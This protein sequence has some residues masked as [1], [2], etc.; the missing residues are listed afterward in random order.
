M[1]H[2]F[3]R[4]QDF[5]NSTKQTDEPKQRSYRKFEDI[6]T[7]LRIY[8]DIKRYRGIVDGEE[9]LITAR[10]MKSMQLSEWLQSGR[11]ESAQAAELKE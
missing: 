11:C 2:Y 3:F 5:F 7:C 1:Q 4:F 8:A 10:K 9:D 6:R